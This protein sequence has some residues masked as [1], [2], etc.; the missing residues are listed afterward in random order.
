MSQV[1]IESWQTDGRAQNGSTRPAN[2][3]FRLLRSATSRKDLQ[4]ETTFSLATKPF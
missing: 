2:Y 3:L 1:I 4:I